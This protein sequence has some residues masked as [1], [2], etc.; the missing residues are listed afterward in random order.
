MAL[1]VKKNTALAVEIESTE[2]TYVAPTAATS[3]V[4]CL[5]DGLEISKSKELLERNI[6]TA[7]VGKTSPLTGQFQ[8]SGTI[9]VEARASSTAGGAPEADKLLRSAL[10]QRKQISSAVTT[11][12][13]GNTGSVLQIQDADI[14]AFAIGDIIMIKEAGAY[15]VS[16]V[17]A[18]DTTLG[19]A[20]ITLLIAKP[21]GSFSNSVV[22]EKSTI[23]KVA[24]SGHPALSISKWV[25][26]AILEQVVGAKVSSLSLDNFSTG[27]LPSMS[28][29]FEG[30]NF[31]SSVT[32]IPY[33]PS[34][35]SSRPPI[36]LDARAYMDTTAL[37]INELTLSLEN[38]LGFE[39]SIS[40]PNGR[41][42]SR[43]TERGITGTFNP[44]KLDNSVANFTKYKNNTSFKLFA[45][46]AVPTGVAG[47]FGQVVAV[48][49]PNCIITEMG[50]A[51]QDGLLQEPITFSANRGAS[52]T[53]DEIFLAFV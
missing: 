29:G 53:T 26:G 49:M 24:D 31:D 13:S 28:F 19:A 2:G 9:P 52:G 27:Q 18:V 10:G 22:I 50:E 15:H 7:S 37:E 11:K 45:Y 12:N 32:A 48:Y 44:Y 5:S 23:Y 39:T 20:N 42:A 25:E 40:A 35:Q 34:Y 36:V 16:P 3:F 51:D 6:F 14:A 1:T 33:T 47:E 43:V 17:S 21:S 30:L 8:A 41:I 4:Q 46:A 38:T